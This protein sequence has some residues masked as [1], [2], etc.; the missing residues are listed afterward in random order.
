M[1][2]QGWQF[3]RK[4][5]VAIL[6][7]GLIHTG[8]VIWFMAKLDA[9]MEVAEKTLDSRGMKGIETLNQTAQNTSDISGLKVEV[10][11]LKEAI[12]RIDGN[13]QVIVNR[14]Y[15]DKKNR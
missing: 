9:R 14:I 3:D 2:T 10:T 1:A 13:L 15:D 4:I 12:N 11:G 6:I 7:G 5:P 8:C